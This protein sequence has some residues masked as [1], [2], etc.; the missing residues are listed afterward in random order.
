[1]PVKLILL[2]I[3]VLD[4]F[5]ASKLIK[6]N[7]KKFNKNIFIIIVTA[8]DNYTSLSQEFKNCLAD[9]ILHKPVEIE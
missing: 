6:E 3:Q 2:I 5:E 7:Y 8:Y 9:K 1:M 4:G